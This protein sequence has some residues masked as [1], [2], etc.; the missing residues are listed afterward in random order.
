MKSYSIKDLERLSGINASTIRV[1]ER[2]YSIIKPD[3]TSTNRRRYGDHELRKII[4]ISILNRNGLKI[5]TIAALSDTEIEKKVVFLSKESNHYSSQVE[6]LILLMIGHDEKGINDLLNR[7]MI[8]LGVEETITGIVFPFFNRIGMMWQNGSTGIGSEHF[9]SNLIRQRIIASTESLPYF[10]MEGSKRVILF[11]PE[12]E[13]H[14]IGLLF[15]NYITR[16]L[17]HET[18]YLGQSTPLTSVTG[19]SEKWNPDIVIT[20][21][22]SGYPDPEDLIRELSS[23]FPDKKV[24]VSGILANLAEDLKLQNIFPLRSVNDLKSHL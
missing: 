4:N 22:M 16:K 3:R 8:N 5:S 11:L 2:R 24:L 19:T 23:S 7:S 18:L 17:G 1:W 21:L 12:N 10:T 15:Y 13:L 20:G 6:S 14:E 9:V